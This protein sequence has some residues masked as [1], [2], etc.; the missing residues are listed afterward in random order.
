M[1]ELVSLPVPPSEQRLNL[2]RALPQTAPRPC[3]RAADLPISLRFRD[4]RKALKLV[5]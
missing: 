3:P 5:R 2:R 4:D 1:A